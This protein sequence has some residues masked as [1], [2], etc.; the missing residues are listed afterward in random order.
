MMEAICL[1]PH[2]GIALNPE[3]SRYRLAVAAANDLVLDEAVSSLIEDL[4]RIADNHDLQLD[5]SLHDEAGERQW[6]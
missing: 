2:Q 5:A 6:S 4:Y 1:A 3:R